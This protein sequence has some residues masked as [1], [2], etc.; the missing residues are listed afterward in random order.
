MKF[1]CL[2][3]VGT[4]H[5]FSLV[6]EG[7]GAPPGSDSSSTTSASAGAYGNM[8][9]KSIDPSTGHSSSSTSSS[10]HASGVVTSSSPGHSATP[11]YSSSGAQ[12]QVSSSTLTASPSTHGGSSS[13]NKSLGGLSFLRGVLPPGMIPKYMNSEWSYAQVRGL[14]SRSICA[15]IGELLKYLLVCLFN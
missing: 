14:E 6:G 1:I 5:I 15:F 11:H 9:P 2:F 10:Y 3:R 13:G 12:N 4:V 8:R 7:P